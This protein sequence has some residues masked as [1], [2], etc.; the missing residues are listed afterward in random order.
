MRVL[1]SPYASVPSSL[2]PGFTY[3][4]WKHTALTPT[5]AGQLLTIEF[6]APGGGQ[7]T[8]TS[9]R[10]CDTNGHIGPSATGYPGYG[11]DR[12]LGAG[13]PSRSASGRATASPRRRPC[14]WS[15]THF[16]HRPKPAMYRYWSWR[17]Q[18]AHRAETRIERVTWNVKEYLCGALRFGIDSRRREPGRAVLQASL[19]ATA[20]SEYRRCLGVW[21]L[22]FE[23]PEEDVSCRATLAVRGRLH[24][25]IT[26]RG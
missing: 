7:I 15:H 18:P 25:Q 16:P 8:W 4:D 22:L 2:P 12:P 26:R 13:T 19:L 21:S 3:I 1:V 23:I 14:G 20:D 5:V 11:C 17:R 9:S 6:V 24:G 10:A